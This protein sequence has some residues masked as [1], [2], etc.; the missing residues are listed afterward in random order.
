MATGVLT[1]PGVALSKVTNVLVT[2]SPV[3]S[4]ALAIGAPA[5][6]VPNTSVMPIL[7]RFIAVFPCLVGQRLLR[8]AAGP[9]TIRT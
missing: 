7:V 9:C 8:I 2:V 1:T 3:T 4:S 6:S 5:H